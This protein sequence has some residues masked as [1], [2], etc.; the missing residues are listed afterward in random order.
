VP[1]TRA[2][3]LPLPW[4][5]GL[6]APRRPRCTR[7]PGTCRPRRTAP[8]ELGRL[9]AREK[10]GCHCVTVTGTRRQRSYNFAI[11]S[12]QNFRFFF[13]FLFCYLFLAFFFGGSAGGIRTVEEG[14]SQEVIRAGCSR[15][16]RWSG[17]RAGSL[18]MT[19]WKGGRTM[20]PKSVFTLENTRPRPASV[21]VPLLEILGPCHI[22][23]GVRLQQEQP[24]VVAVHSTVVVGNNMKISSAFVA[25]R[26][27]EVLGP[28]H[29]RDLHA[30][31]AAKY[32]CSVSSTGTSSLIQYRRSSAFSTYGTSSAPLVP[33]NREKY[34]KKKRFGF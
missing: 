18:A 30:S 28:R 5:G 16:G 19:G 22:R 25:G 26:L 32:L 29:I 23:N 20:A 27:P 2:G 21:V 34:I 4:P 7:P 14:H 11:F 33:A 15:V 6:R 3:C 9:G 13:V 8:I 12:F 17:G 1:R 31:A 24:T 10:G